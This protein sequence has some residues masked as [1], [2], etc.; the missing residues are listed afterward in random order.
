[1]L[2][3]YWGSRVTPSTPGVTGPSCRGLFKGNLATMVKVVPQSAVQFAVY[4]TAQVGTTMTAAPVC[5]P[6]HHAQLH[7]AV[8]HGLAAQLA[9]AAGACNCVS[10]QT[11]GAGWLDMIS[12][13]RLVLPRR[14]QLPYTACTARSSA[15]PT[16]P[17]TSRAGAQDLMVAQARRAGAVQTTDTGSLTPAQHLLAGSL[18]G[19]LRSR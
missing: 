11:R 3:L 4:D 7:A 1:M 8:Q 10:V 14:L 15:Q 13:A 12:S 19:A 5:G 9:P 16:S 17:H 18:A 2:L 6:A